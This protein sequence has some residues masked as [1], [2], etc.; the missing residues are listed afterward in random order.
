MNIYVFIFYLMCTE[1]G[2]VAVKMLQ[3]ESSLLPELKLFFHCLSEIFIE[4]SEYE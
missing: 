3:R 1:V 2:D 4:I